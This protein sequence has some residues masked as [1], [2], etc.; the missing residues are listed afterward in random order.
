MPQALLF[1]SSPLDI[2]K[3]RSTTIQYTL[4]E[5]LRDAREEVNQEVKRCTHVAPKFS[6]D[7]K[8]A[9]LRIES[10]AQVHPVSSYQKLPLLQMWQTLTFLDKVIATR[11]AGHLKSSKLQVVMV[12]NS[13]YNPGLTNFS[14]RVA[15][16]ARFRV[17]SGELDVNIIELLKSYAARSPGLTEA[18]GE[19]FARGHKQASGGIVP[20]EMFEKLWSVMMES[21]AES[22]DEV[23]GGSPRK[24]RKKEYAQKNTLESWVKR[25]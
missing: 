14:C 13:G 16:C 20:T 19:D 3:P 4:W 6:G 21:P 15:Q 11:W 23:A 7:G 5:R 9:L 25:S 12:A 18:M 2:V 1:S 17:A 10:A 24:K 8:V 22:G